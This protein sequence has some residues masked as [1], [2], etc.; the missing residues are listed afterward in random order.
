VARIRRR[1]PKV[2]ILLRGEIPASP[3]RRRCNPRF[4][5]TSLKSSGVAAQHLYEATYCARGEMESRIKERQL[6]LFGALIRL[7]QQKPS[8]DLVHAL[9]S[10]ADEDCQVLLGRLGLAR[11]DL[12]LHVIVALESIETPRAMRIAQMVCNR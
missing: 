8:P 7:S 6:D 4:V 2:R 1:W 12:A 11:P 5:V 9:A 10:V 3:A